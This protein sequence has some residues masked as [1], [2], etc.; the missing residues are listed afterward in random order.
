MDKLHNI[1]YYVVPYKVIGL[2]VWAWTLMR[3]SRFGGCMF[4]ETRVRRGKVRWQKE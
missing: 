4:E 2:G 1:N 3:S